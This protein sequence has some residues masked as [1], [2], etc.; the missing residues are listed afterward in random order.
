LKIIE[1][2][3]E[4]RKR[5]S[6]KCNCKAHLRIKL[7]K[8]H[9]IFP[10]EWRVTSFVAEHNHGLLTESEVRFLPAYRTILE[11]DCERIFLLKEGGL[12]VRQIMRVMEL[13]KDVKHGYLPF[14]EKDV[15]NLFLKANVISQYFNVFYLFILLNQYGLIIIN[16]Y[17]YQD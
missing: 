13:E 10:M 5:E 11:D 6:S 16:M 17:S 4:Q 12:S 9:D 8:Y 7:Q 2:S 14:T 3:K 15:R 1:P